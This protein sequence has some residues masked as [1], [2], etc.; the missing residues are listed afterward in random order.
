MRVVNKTELRTWAN[1]KGE[2][3]LFSVNLIDESVSTFLTIVP[4]LL[5]LMSYMYHRVKSKLRHSM[6]L[7]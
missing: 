2:G 6:T 1:A 5:H 4:C 3:K 7:R